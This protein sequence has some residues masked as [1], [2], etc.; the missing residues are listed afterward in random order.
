MLSTKFC[1]Y[2]CKLKLKH[3]LDNDVDFDIQMFGS[4]HEIREKQFRSVRIL[5]QCEDTFTS[6]KL[7]LNELRNKRLSFFDNNK[8]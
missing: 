2:I 4:L 8:K 5:D 3:D 6:K 7:N 1:N